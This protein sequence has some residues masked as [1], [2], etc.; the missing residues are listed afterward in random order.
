MP[1]P[2]LPDSRVLPLWVP[3]DPFLYFLDGRWQILFHQYT[4]S[5]APNNK[6]VPCAAMHDPNAGEDPSLDVVGGH[7]MS[8]TADLFGEWEYNY[9]TA[10]Y[11]MQVNWAAPSTQAPPL[12]LRR[13]RPKLLFG[14]D[15]RPT[16][17]FNGVSIGDA[18]TGDPAQRNSFT[19]AQ[20]LR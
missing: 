19:F 6:S 2:S 20:A 16:H 15:G 9:W 8:L 17:L 14:L 1:A 13:E 4:L 12:L 5:T 18:T 3:Q 11:A 7:A 10:A